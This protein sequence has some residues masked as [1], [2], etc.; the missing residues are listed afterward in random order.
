MAEINDERCVN[1]VTVEP[2]SKTNYFF[3]PI[4]QLQ[5]GTGVRDV[6]VHIKQAAKRLEWV[7][8]YPNSNEGWICVKRRKAFD[9]IISI[10]REPLLVQ[11]TGVAKPII[12]SPQNTNYQVTIRLPENSSQHISNII[13]LST[14]RRINL[15]T[16]AATTENDTSLGSDEERTDTREKIIIACGTYFGPDNSPESNDSTA[17]NNSGFTHISNSTQTTYAVSSPTYY[18]QQIYYPKPVWYPEPV[19]AP[20]CWCPQCSGYP[21]PPLYVDQ[22][23]Y[24]AGP[25]V[26]PDN[27][28]YTQPVGP[29]ASRAVPAGP[30]GESLYQI[31]L[32]NFSRNTTPY[33]VEKMVRRFVRQCMNDRWFQF[34]YGN[35]VIMRTKGDA[36][37]LRRILD[38]RL[39]NGVRIRAHRGLLMSPQPTISPSWPGWM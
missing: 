30:P 16:A 9:K 28:C 11:A 29:P 31:T 21:H 6:W 3:V 37:K 32:S 10:L 18:S 1:A 8:I 38:G 4:S 20:P 13:N 23:G 14:K 33:Q 7:S 39:L 15:S 36:R 22:Q 27:L 2:G 35:T 19:Y 5:E 24:Y 25:G 26:L 34:A 17:T 12:A